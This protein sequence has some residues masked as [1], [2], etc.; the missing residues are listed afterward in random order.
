LQVDGLDVFGNDEVILEKALREN[1]VSKRCDDFAD[2][3][4]VA[5]ATYATGYY[6]RVRLGPKIMEGMRWLLDH[7][8]DVQVSSLA[9]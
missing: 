2:L 5:W 8:K 9:T 4:L 6:S 1:G 7:C 3:G